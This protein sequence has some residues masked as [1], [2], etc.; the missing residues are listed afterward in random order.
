MKELLT[1]LVRLLVDRP[2][3][4]LVEETHI[5]GTIRYRIRVA[6]ADV[7]R[8]IGRQGRVIRALRV[9]MR[10]VAGSALNRVEVELHE[11]C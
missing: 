9:V 4:V 5:S 3:S 11:E 1:T 2:E 6:G 8:V 10:S 7:G